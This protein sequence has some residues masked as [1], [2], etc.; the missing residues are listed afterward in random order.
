MKLV[1]QLAAGRGELDVVADSV[2]VESGA[3]L[4]CRDGEPVLI[5]AA[6]TWVV[7]HP[8]GQGPKRV[9]PPPPTRQ[10]EQEEPRLLA[11]AQDIP[12]AVRRGG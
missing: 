8:A 7:V 9:S 2:T 5:L 4:A 12:D 1:V 3:L 11:Q 10:T 6:K